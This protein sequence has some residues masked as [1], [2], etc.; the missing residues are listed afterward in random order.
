MVYQPRMLWLGGILLLA[1]VAGVTWLAF[2]FGIRHA[3]GELLELRARTQILEADI[4]RLR[5]RGREYAE[6]TAILERGSQ[7]DAAAYK[8]V[9]QD[10]ATLERQ[11]DELERELALYRGIVSPEKVLAGVQIQSIELETGSEPGHIR[12]K[13]LL[14]QLSQR[15]NMVSGG[16]ELRIRGRRDDRPVTLDVSAMAGADGKKLAYKFRYFQ[17]LEGDFQLPAGFTPQEVV[18]KTQPKGKKP[19]P[20]ERIFS[21]PI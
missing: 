8:E 2:E 19:V 18:V 13:L 7:V 17:H 9:E 20:I 1:V 3:G 12:F 15:H 11:I 10:Y 4:V 14:T 6:R 21:W 16:V 5:Q